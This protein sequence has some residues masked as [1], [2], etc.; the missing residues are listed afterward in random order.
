MRPARHFFR[1][2]VPDVEKL[3]T[4]AGNAVFSGG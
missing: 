4:F 3:R 1:Y 2:A